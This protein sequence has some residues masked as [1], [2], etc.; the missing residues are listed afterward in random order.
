MSNHRIGLWMY[1]NCGGQEIE[2][3]IVSQLQ[4]REIEAIVGL[5]LAHA[6]AHDKNIFCNGHRL[7]ELDLFFS[8]NAG[9]QTPF[10]VYLYQ[11]LNTMMP[12]INNYE[13]FA[14]TEDKFRTAHRL[15]INDIPTTDYIVCSKD[16]IGQLKE[17]M[18]FW[19]GKAI[20]KPVDGWGGNGI[21]KLENERDLDLLMPYISQHHAPQFYLE[22][23][24]EN[25][26]TDYRIDIV[27]NKFVACYGRKAA[28][29]AWKTNVTSG[30]SVIMREP[31]PEVVDLALRAA[32]VTGLEVAGVD[33]IYDIEYQ[34]YVVIEVNGIPA[35][36]TPDQ[37]L[38]G[39][40]F[41]DT[42]IQYL[43]DLI[44]RTVNQPKQQTGI[45]P[46]I[47]L[48]TIDPMLNPILQ[49]EVPTV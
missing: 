27:D 16:N 33:I 46:D 13:S 32:K 40:N 8:Y 39:L 28:P 45:T 48:P 19:Q 14:L 41:N 21:I 17:H 47:S 11:T 10:Q 24:I 12:M 20:C 23:V 22:R 6:T 30:G 25:D 18:R 36:A 35:F 9:Q 1:E 44:E 3:K 34:R 4:E 43:V 42:K 49:A 7:D 31:V 26:F 29:G 5:N 15:K 2:R 37:E 38:Q